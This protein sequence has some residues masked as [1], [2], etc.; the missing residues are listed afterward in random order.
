MNEDDF[1]FICLVA[2][3]DWKYASAMC[4]LWN[5]KCEGEFIWEEMLY[6]DV[7]NCPVILSRK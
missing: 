6:C 5:M 2:D 7:T 3:T 4:W 1:N